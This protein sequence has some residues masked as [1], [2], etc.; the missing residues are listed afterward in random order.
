M[1]RSIGPARS[2]AHSELHMK[3]KKETTRQVKE[4]W[5]AG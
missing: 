2:P 3:L 1:T 5:S 4:R